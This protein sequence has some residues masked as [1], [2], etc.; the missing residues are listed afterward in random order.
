MRQP[1]L[2][3]RRRLRPTGR[4]NYRLLM[5]G[6]ALGLVAGGFGP[7]I[8]QNLFGLRPERPEALPV[9]DPIPGEPRRESA[10]RYGEDHVRQ[11][12][13]ILRPPAA[14]PAPYPAVV[15]FHGGG[16]THGS[17]RNVSG[18]SDALARR[19]F[20]VLSAD[21]RLLPLQ[22]MPSIIADAVAMTRYAYERASDYDLDP[23]RL[24]TMGRS[25]GAHLALMAAYTSGVPLR[26]A[27]SEAGPTDFDPVMWDGSVR[28]AMMKR[29]SKD[30]DVREVSP[31]HVATAAAPPTLLVHGCRDATVP[32]AHSRILQVRLEGL[33]VPVRLLALPR[34]G[35]N[36][37]MWRWRLGFAVVCHWLAQ[38][39]G[40]ETAA[41]P[42]EA[43]SAAPAP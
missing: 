38:T 10:L 23:T 17:R 4:L 35:H 21:Y 33:G 22:D 34:T 39:M 11:R 25:A 8:A 28:G 20:A 32:F 15:L 31:L 41:S 9:P 27:I 19:G 40:I 7:A 12:F 42:D 26:A 13:D 24:A 30:V 18:I 29:F 3:S 5:W 37:L 1:S 36:P 2:P 43:P 14:A 6:T 16:F